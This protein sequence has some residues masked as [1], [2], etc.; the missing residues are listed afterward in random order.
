MHTMLSGE[1][2]LNLFVVCIISHYYEN[3]KKREK[4]D[5]ELNWIGVESVKA[6]FQKALGAIWN[7]SKNLSWICKT[8]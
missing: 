3:C 5:T 2:L 8:D 1:Q 7:Y 6:R 4:G